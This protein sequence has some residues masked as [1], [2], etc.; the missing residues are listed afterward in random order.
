MNLSKQII[1]ET[2][3]KNIDKNEY[4]VF[5]F[6]S[7]VKWDY[8]N[9]SDYDIWIR[10]KKKINFIDLLKLKRKLNELPYI[11]DIVDFNNV[12][13]DFKNIALNNI[14]KWN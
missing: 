9:N 2:I 14:E 3:F 11:I 13:E 10:G 4:D 6:W 1:K 7:R 8:K 5:L 12:D